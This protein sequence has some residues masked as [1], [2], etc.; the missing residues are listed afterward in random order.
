VVGIDG[1]GPADLGSDEVAEARAL[2]RRS[3]AAARRVGLEI[4]ASWSGRRLGPDAPSALLRA[5]TVSYPWLRGERSDPA[6]R[7][8]RLLWE[9]PRTLPVTEVEAAY[10]IASDR[11]RRSL[12]HL[13]ALRRDGDGLAAVAFLISDDGPTDLLPLPIAGLLSPVLDVVDAARLVPAL[14]SVAARRGWAWHASDLLGDLAGDGR[15]DPASEDVVVAGLA[16]LALSLL[17]ASDRTRAV[18]GER[19]DPSRADRHRLRA[20]GRVLAL[21]QGPEPTAVLRRMLAA[22]DPRVAAPAAVALL[23]RREPVAS[24]RLELIARDPEA[25]GD[26]V[27][28]LAELDL[29]G[30]LDGGRTDG[31]ARAESDLVRWLA[32]DTELARPPDEVEHLV[33]LPAG[34]D[35]VHGQVHLFRFRV[36]APHWSCA[37]GWMVGAAGPYRPD[38]SPGA[39][40][41]P[42]ASSLYGAED[43]D[44]PDGHLDAILDALGDWPG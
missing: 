39:G 11:V 27:E 42:F 18:P 7:F 12:L 15:L 33:A 38:G 5:A 20:V 34:D 44:R 1:G 8:A 26:L 37:R 2:L 4:V 32:G 3:D 24:E 23:R 28:G 14:V 40:V 16:P 19:G 35:T 13:L 10:L 36:R 25:R 21:V 17:D 9:H 29:L 41:A 30:L 43:E 22:V 6:D 31:R